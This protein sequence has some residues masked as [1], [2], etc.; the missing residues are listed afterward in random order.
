VQTA[1][2]TGVIRRHWPTLAASVAAVAALV[3]AAS[4]RELL[5]NERIY[6]LQACVALAGAALLA[7]GA[8]LGRAGRPEERGRVRDRC[9]AVLAAA[10]VWLGLVLGGSSLERSMRVFD[11]VH[12]YVGSK[13]FSEL[14]YDGL[15]DCMVVADAEAGLMPLIERSRVRDLRSNELRPAR[16]VLRDAAALKGRFT[17]ERWRAFAHDVGWF[18]VRVAPEHW[19]RLRT[20]HG[21]NPPPT[22]GLLGTLLTNTAA[23]ST[24]QLGLLILI[25]PLLLAAL[26]A[27]VA[28]A[29]GWRVTCVALI[30]FGTNFP[31][32]WSWVGGSILRFDWL[33]AAV[34]GICMLKLAR[35]A[36]AGV[37]LAFSCAVRVFPVP[38]LGGIAL[39]WIVRLARDGR[40]AFGKTERRFVAGVLGTGVVMVALATLVGGGP[41][42]W[43]DFAENSRKHLSTP[44]TNHVG[45]RSVLAYDHDL[46]EAVTVDPRQFDPHARWIEGRRA[47]FAARAPLF[48]ILAAGFVALAA[49]ALRGRPDWLAAVA[50]AASIAILLE[51]TSYYHSIL[52]VL[53]FL[54]P[55]RRWIGVG[56]LLLAALPWIPMKLGRPQDEVFL[57]TNVLTVALVVG[58]MVGLLRAR[59]AVDPEVSAAPAARRNP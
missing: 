31:A 13:Y 49:A 48:W 20:D 35:P 26:F 5:P 44:L 45:L 52:L 59:P 22:W 43:T 14:G 10:T 53:A 11:A 7:W 32:S 9:L 16:D 17:A 51:L 34:A 4:H 3:W 8:W 50:G 6:T 33:F 38:I 58:S 1:R 56:L 2:K 57:F 12:Y 39:G 25:D 28:R 24:T 41:R 55:E 19:V 18:R 54:W 29:F 23:A 27:C 30:Y 46:R 36:L 21:Y 40:A 42:V 47:T 37:L 15:Y